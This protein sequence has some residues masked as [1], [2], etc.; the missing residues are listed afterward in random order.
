MKQIN[1][2]LLSTFTLSLFL[3]TLLVL[4]SSSASAFSS[5]PKSPPT[6]PPDCVNKPAGCYDSLGNKAESGSL[7]AETF[8][9]FLSESA[10]IPGGCTARATK[11]LDEAKITNPDDNI[12]ACGCIDGA[13]FD[14]Q[15]DAAKRCCGD[16]SSDCGM[17]SKNALC[18]IDAE[19]RSARWLIPSSSKNDI[20]FVG[21]QNK[22]KVLDNTAWI[23]CASFS[24]RPIGSPAHEY[25]CTGQGGQGS[26]IECCGSAACY[27]KTNGKRLSAG[28]SALVSGVTHY[29]AT[30]R[31]FTTDL[32]TK[33]EQSCKNAKTPDGNPANLTWTGTKCCSE[34]DDPHEYYNDQTG[35][36]WNSKPVISINFVDAVHDVVNF[37]GKFHG[38]AISKSNYNSQNNAYLSLSDKHTSQILVADDPY[39]TNDPDKSYYCSFREKWMA[40]G[41]KDR[42]SFKT[43]PV[44]VPNTN[45]TSQSECCAPS[46]CWDGQSCIDDQSPH[47][48][49]E[50]ALPDFRCMAG[51]WI[52]AVPKKTINGEAEGYCPN[53]TQCMVNPSG[54]AADNNNPT[55][56][57]QCI[58]SQQFIKDDYCS[59]GDWSS[60]TAQ[61]ALT[62]LSSKNSGSYTLF[63]DKTEN[64]LNLLD[65]LTPSGKQAS[66]YFG[67]NANNVCVLQQNNNIAVG[68]S[69]NTPLTSAATLDLFSVQSCSGAQ[70]DDGQYHKCDTSGT[71]WYNKKLESAIYGKN[72]LSINSQS[73]QSFFASFLKDPL[74]ALLFALRQRLQSSS[75]SLPSFEGQSAKFQR[76]YITEQGGKRIFGVLQGDHATIEY[77]NFNDINICEFAS[78]FTQQL[79]GTNAGIECVKTGQTYRLLLQGGGLTT[80][81]PEQVWPD[82]TS[83]VRIS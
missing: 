5:S 46:Q 26:L 81:Q 32:D 35:G 28:G 47:P 55:K 72:S 3:F 76:L 27:S 64:T 7:T 50:N 83:K 45:S 36:C 6:P 61:I 14:S 56:N 78:Q 13:D 8:S 48:T 74:D 80:F 68:A 16:D 2:I 29:C 66:L 49:S 9:Y 42:S 41:G 25:L 52:T 77:S 67:T 69:F 63:C 33:D 21:C 60:R 11:S 73:T 4:V 20:I 23:D 82:L 22:E 18:A 51:N 71:L 10:Y 62:L 53:A 12:G 58:A 17:L 1:T 37:N 34:A 44:Q 57:P 54:N 40:T 24:K 43:S 19:G 31:T 30:D 79:G 38:C 65:Y 39:C 70:Q 59:S 15:A 75:F